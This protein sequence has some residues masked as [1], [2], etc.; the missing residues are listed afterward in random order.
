MRGYQYPWTITLHATRG[1]DSCD[2]AKVIS[3]VA[4]H[5]PRSGWMVSFEWWRSPRRKVRAAPPVGREQPRHVVSLGQQKGCLPIKNRFRAFLLIAMS[6]LLNSVAHA[7]AVIYVYTDPQ[8]TPLAEADINGNITATYDYV[9]YGSQAMGA[10]LNGPGYTGHVNDPE[11][12]FVYMQARY[13]DPSTGRFLSKDPIGPAIGNAFN[14]NRYEYA[15]N[16]PI[17]NID[18][19]GR[20]TGSNISNSDGTCA[21][22]GD[23]TTQASSAH[24]VGASALQRANI[25]GMHP[26]SSSG[27]SSKS[28]DR[29]R[30]LTNDEINSAESVYEDKVDYSSVRVVKGK[31]VFTQGSGYAV[32]PNGNIYFPQDCGNLVSCESGSYEGLFIHEMMHVLQY[33]SGVNVLGRGLL[34]QTGKFLSFGLYDPYM[35]EYDSSR[36]FSSYNIEQQGDIAVQIF[37]GS[38]PNNIDYNGVKQ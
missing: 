23:F 31:Y 3:D 26:T 1:R 13:Y 19:D 6:S 4:D 37:Y 35:Y 28:I 33:Q 34:L 29:G 10:P 32:T 11:S 38:Y 9:P 5:P 15:N 17:N 22:S 2:S 36:K 21:S 8:G 16:N 27:R 30:P 12:G 25:L 20:C 14:F 18:A 7:G 24:L